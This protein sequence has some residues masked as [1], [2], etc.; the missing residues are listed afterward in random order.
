MD[1][2]LYQEQSSSIFR[3]FRQMAATRKPSLQLEI[4]LDH[5]T[6]FGS[7]MKGTANP[8]IWILILL[9]SNS[10]ILFQKGFL[11]SKIR[12]WICRKEREIRFKI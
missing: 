12:I 10:I 2:L 1:I 5:L 6:N 3:C 11:K 4:L 7:T 8:L 9:I